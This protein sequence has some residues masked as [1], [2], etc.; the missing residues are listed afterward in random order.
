VDHRTV[1]PRDLGRFDVVSDTTGSEL[2]AYRGL[3]RP[4]GRMVT[5]A[6]DLSRLTASLGCIAASAVHS[7]SRVRAFSGSP[8]RPLLDDV[9]RHVRDGELRPMVDRV[10]PLHDVAEAHRAL[11]AGGVRGKYVVE[12]G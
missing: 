12:V 4:G 9:A 3:L 1:R 5:I 11:E 2:P 10:F 7:R 6:F 8:K